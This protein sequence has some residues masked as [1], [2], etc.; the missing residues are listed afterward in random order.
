MNANRKDV[1]KS[2]FEQV[3]ADAWFNNKASE[4]VTRLENNRC[5]I[6]LT[7]KQKK[8]K[9]RRKAKKYDL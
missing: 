8:Q 9:R 7:N 1:R 4:A 5:H 2:S 6:T 3:I